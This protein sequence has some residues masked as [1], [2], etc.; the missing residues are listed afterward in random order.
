MMVSGGVDSIAAAHWLKF[1]YHADISILHFNHDIQTANIQM[2]K[3][4]LSFMDDFGFSGMVIERGAEYTDTSENGLRQ[5]RLAQ[6]GIIDEN[7]FITAHHLNDA[8]ENYLANCFDGFPEYMPIQ[9]VSKFENF[10]VLHPFLTA[11]KKDFIR[12]VADNKL[13]K[14]VVTDPTNTETTQ[15]RNWIRNIII[16][17]LESRKM[18]IQTVVRKK[19]YSK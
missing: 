1:R 4:V 8:V 19:Y 14:Y 12:Y 17:E 2:E 5:F 16:P 10:E 9:P 18:G 15:K 3:S 13:D 6:M 11:T 7:I